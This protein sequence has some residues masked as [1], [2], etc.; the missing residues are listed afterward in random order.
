[1]ITISVTIAYLVSGDSL[2]PIMN[3]GVVWIACYNRTLIHEPLFTA[4]H[5]ILIHCMVKHPSVPLSCYD[6]IWHYFANDIHVEWH[7]LMC[8][9]LCL[10]KLAACFMI[11]ISQYTPI[12]SNI[13]RWTH[14]RFSYIFLTERLHLYALNVLFQLDIYHEN[15]WV[16]TETV[17][18]ID[19]EKYIWRQY[20]ELL[21]AAIMT[22]CQK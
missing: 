1:M 19:P 5:D 12:S 9:T 11:L 22:S 7:S 8:V 4:D 2:Y 17:P 13:Y 15:D 6:L 21:L 18:N 14:K 20:Q 10:V 16:R 3:K